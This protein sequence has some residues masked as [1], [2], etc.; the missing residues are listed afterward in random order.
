MVDPG[1]PQA[2]RVQAGADRELGRNAFNHPTGVG[3]ILD[4][5]GVLSST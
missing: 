1:R 2:R 5:R 3:A 4:A